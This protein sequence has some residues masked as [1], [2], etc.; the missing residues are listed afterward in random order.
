M[1][2]RDVFVGDDGGGACAGGRDVMAEL[3]KKTCADADIVGTLA[4]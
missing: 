4:E 3:R 1:Q 2:P